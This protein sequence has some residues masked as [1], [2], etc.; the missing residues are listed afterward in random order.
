MARKKPEG[1]VIATMEQ[2]TETLKELCE[3]ER[4]LSAITDQMNADIDAIKATAAR[5]AEP[6]AARAKELGQALLAFAQLNKAE[7]FNKPKSKTTPFG[8]IGF[9]KSTELKTLSK[10]IK[11]ADVVEKLKKYNF[12]AA[13]KIEKKVDKEAMHDWPDERLELVGMRRVIKDKFFIELKAEDLGQK[14]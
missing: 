12:V 6:H 8:T 7:M 13:I 5:S 14:G 2:A 1:P 3:I 9:R 11:I 10:A 4:E